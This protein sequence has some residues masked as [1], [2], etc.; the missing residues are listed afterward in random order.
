MK[1]AVNDALNK[2]VPKAYRRN[3]NVIGIREFRPNKDPRQIIA[4]LTTRY[5]QRTTTE[6][7]KQ[8]ERWRRD[9][10][11]SKPTEELIDRLE[12]CFIFVIYMRPAY[13]QPQLTERAHTQ[14]KRTGLYPTAVVE[15]EG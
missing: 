6:V 2:A 8:D 11:P 3:P 9:W 14:F 15:W 1:G 5:G 12:D 7:H 13:T 10:N 4:L